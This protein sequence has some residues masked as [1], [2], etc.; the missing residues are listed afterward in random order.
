MLIQ[1][2]QKELQEQIQKLN[3]QLL[4]CKNVEKQH[5]YMNGK[6]YEEVDK[7]KK[8][9]EQIKKENAIFKENLQAELLRAKIKK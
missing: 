1:K 6:L 9:L 8:E 3:N 5:K 2:S 4:E 7:L